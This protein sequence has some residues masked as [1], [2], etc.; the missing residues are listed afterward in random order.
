MRAQSRSFSDE[1]SRGKPERGYRHAKIST[2]TEG[3]KRDLGR[4]VNCK[5]ETG[6]GPEKHANRKN[7]RVD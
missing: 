6:G 7:I 2:K 4:G 3:E 1:Y 5:I